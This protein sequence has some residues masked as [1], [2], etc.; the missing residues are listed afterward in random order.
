[1]APSPKHCIENDVRSLSVQTTCVLYRSM[2]LGILPKRSDSLS[3]SFVCDLRKE[4]AT[5][6]VRLRHWN[7]SSYTVPLLHSRVTLCLQD[8]VDSFRTI[9]NDAPVAAGQCMHLRPN[10]GEPRACI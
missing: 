7:N 8:T 10:S 2:L 9:C 1:M 5:I 6:V 4:G 3:A